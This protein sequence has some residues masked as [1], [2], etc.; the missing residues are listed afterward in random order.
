[1]NLGNT[2]WIRIDYAMVRIPKYQ[3]L[4]LEKVCFFAYAKPHGTWR[5]LQGGWLSCRDLGIHDTTS[6]GSAIV[7]L[8]CSWAPRKNWESW[9]FTNVFLVVL[10]WKCLPPTHILLVGTS[11]RG[12]SNGK[13]LR[14]FLCPAK[15]EN[16][17][18]NECYQSPLL[19]VKLYHIFITA[20]FF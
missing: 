2:W 19:W 11:H 17:D 10:A 4:D 18:M 12:L 9:K 13:G 20:W 7:I 5:T 16:S 1:M 15:L 3:W 6:H 14:I 8:W